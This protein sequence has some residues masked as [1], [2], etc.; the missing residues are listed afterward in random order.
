MKDILNDFKRLMIVTVT[1]CLLL[2]LFIFITEPKVGRYLKTKYGIIDTTNGDMW[3]RE[4]LYE[5]GKSNG[6]YWKPF[7]S[8]LKDFKT[9][10]K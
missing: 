1:A 7:E 5:D 3:S 9:D 6:Q 4:W 2:L 8:Q 10:I